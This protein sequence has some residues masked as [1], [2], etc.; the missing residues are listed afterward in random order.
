MINEN[1]RDILGWNYIYVLV[2]NQK[3]ISFCTLAQKD[4]IKDATLFPWIGFVYTNEDYRGYRNSKLVIDAALIQA[5]KLGY[6]K[7]YLA[8]DHI[9]LYEKYGFKYLESRTDIYNEES[10]IYCFEL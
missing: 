3:V 4:C 8:T 10:R 9:G 1:K 2:E 6:A 5:K 7:V